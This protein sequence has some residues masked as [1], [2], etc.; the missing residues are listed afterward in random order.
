MDE[1]NKDS[2]DSDT[3]DD[4]AVTVPGSFTTGGR[5][6]LGS[7]GLI[8]RITRTH[9][10]L[11]H[12][13][14][15]WPSSTAVALADICAVLTAAATDARAVLHCLEPVP[16][17]PAHPRTHTTHTV[18]APTPAALAHLLAALAPVPRRPCAPASLRFLVLVSAAS[19]AHRALRVW[20]TDCAP[21]LASAGAVCD[22]VCTTH[23]GHARAAVAHAPCGRYRAVLAV[24]GDGVLCE[25]LNGALARRDWAAFLRRT[26]LVPVAAG[27]GNALAHSWYRSADAAGAVCHALRGRRAACD[28]FLCVLPRTR[29]HVWGA[30]GVGFGVLADADL[31]SEP[32]RALGPLRWALWG[33]AEIALHRNRAA[34]TLAYLPSR[35]HPVDL[36]HRPTGVCGRNCPQC[37]VH[38]EA[39]EEENSDDGCC[40]DDEEGTIDEEWNKNLPQ[41]QPPQQGQEQGQHFTA[42][43]VD[44]RKEDLDENG[45]PKMYAPLF[46]DV[47][48]FYRPDAAASAAGGGPPGW[49]VSETVL[50]FCAINS[51][52]W[53]SRDNMVT[54]L[55]HRC[56][57]SLDVCLG[58]AAHFSRLGYAQAFARIAHGT[59]VD[60]ACMHDYAKVRALAIVP[61]AAAGLMG[62]DGERIPHGPIAVYVA[63]ALFHTLLYD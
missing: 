63:H 55:A 19:G 40:V 12:P 56:D 20:R 14:C 27:T 4:D 28:A 57:G 30:L 1:C 17:A 59:H 43:L 11:S 21:L 48:S 35:D 8:V 18:A 22:V 53:I 3:S 9:L 42:A 6:W 16:G 50:S 49:V 47:P 62:V 10:V 13:S 32:L 58:T 46:K 36:D 24:G 38:D 52:P 29:Q 37:S 44:D 51:T 60:C 25:A 5:R 34:C 33:T 31:G 7:T 15:L 45:I 23:A 26:A 2:S 54:P 41:G 39:E 61:R